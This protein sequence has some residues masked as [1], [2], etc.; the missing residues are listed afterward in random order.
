M[1]E[2]Q[3]R[4]DLGVLLVHGIGLQ[5]P[6]DTLTVAGGALLD[7][8]KRWFDSSG[9][10]DRAVVIESTS[11]AVDHRSEGS[12]YARLRVS[13]GARNSTWRLEESFWADAFHPPKLLDLII[14]SAR[15]LLW[16]PLM[17]LM[18][19]WAVAWQVL[20]RNARA[21]RLAKE[22]GIDV[23]DAVP[24]KG[25]QDRAAFYLYFLLAQLPIIGLI[26]PLLLVAMLVIL[27]VS[28]IPL[29]YFKSIAQWMQRLLSRSIGDSYFFVSRPL[30]RSAI[31]TRVEED[32]RS[33]AARSSSVVVVAH[34]QG[35]AIA[36]QVLLKMIRG[37]TLPENISLITYG[38]GIQRL[39]AMESALR[40]PRRWTG[41]GFGIYLALGIIYGLAVLAF[42]GQSPGI[43]LTMIGT[44]LIASTGVLVI[45]TK[46]LY[47]SSNPLPIDWK[48][49]YATHDP[50]SA[51]PLKVDGSI[52]FMTA[53]RASIFG[54]L[55]EAA[56]AFDKKQI[57]VVNRRSVFSDHTSYWKATDEFVAVVAEDLLQKSDMPLPQTD[58]RRIAVGRLRRHWRCGFL[59]EYRV[60]L[61]AGLIGA[62]LSPGVLKAAYDFMVRLSMNSWIAEIPWIGKMLPSWVKS[63]ASIASIF[64]VAMCVFLG[65]LLARICWG[66]W[67]RRAMDA[68]FEETPEF[69][70]KLPV[71]LFISWWVITFACIAGL[72]DVAGGIDWPAP[73]TLALVI[74]IAVSAVALARITLG[75][76]SR[77]KIRAEFGDAGLEPATV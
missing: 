4:N 72:V 20:E 8:L 32:I 18:P 14:W 2:S 43:A 19:R 27:V 73:M 61:A 69:A 74:S 12:A 5:R 50:V 9:P 53:E 76:G 39:R 44:V 56:E 70:K 3:E 49:I 42:N 71:I 66:R 75:E 47:E 33:L 35:A 55:L 36:H 37:N 34:S 15:M 23:K 52:E 68:Y 28:I 25:E 58:S 65:Y 67:N 40:S 60:M 29:D 51:G 6:G 46:H 59:S 21:R 45:A 30:V 11:L 54:W 26:G 16:L 63:N 1:N 48:N 13:T 57:A 31:E 62:C 22:K 17:Y 10:S 64:L 41:F 24:N 7:W 38:Q 77:K